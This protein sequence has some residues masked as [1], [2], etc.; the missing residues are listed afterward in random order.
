MYG[1]DVIFHDIDETKL[2]KLKNN[3]YNVT[4]SIM[5][6]VVNS[7]ISFICVPTPTVNHKMDLSYI[8]EATVNIAKALHEKNNYHLVVVK[9]TVLPSTT[10]TK[11]VPLLE[12]YSMLKAGRDFGICV[13]PEFLRQTT[14]LED[15][16][17]PSRIVI[18][19]YDKRSGD[20]LETLYTP[21]NAPIFRTGLDTAEMIKY[22]ANCFLATKISFFNEIY[23]ICKKMGYDPHFIAEVVSLDPRIGKY[24]I[25][26]GRPFGG[27]CLPK[28]LDALI[29]FLKERSINPQILEAVLKVN[30]VMKH[31]EGIYE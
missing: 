25:Y 29:H 31:M 10:R 17:K 23:I 28:D 7:D 6:A 18:G 8:V 30:E 11:I 14:A 1:N 2:L 5:E 27:P 24:G 15:F 13:N 19:E 22:V 16:L 3:G 20:L 26:G 9:S 21:F 12:E 4:N